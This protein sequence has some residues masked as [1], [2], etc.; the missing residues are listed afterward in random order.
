MKRISSL[1]HH[2]VYNDSSNS[3]YNSN[4]NN[5]KDDDND[6]EEWQFIVRH[7]T[8]ILQKSGQKSV[9]LMG[10]RFSEKHGLHK[11]T[12]VST[13]RRNITTHSAHHDESQSTRPVA[14][15]VIW[16]AGSV[17]ERTQSSARVSTGQ[18][19]DSRLIQTTEQVSKREDNGNVRRAGYVSKGGADDNGI[20]WGAE[21][22]SS[23]GKT[24][25]DVLRRREA[26]TDG[27]GE[28]PSKGRINE[29]RKLLVKK[30]NTE[31]EEDPKVSNYSDFCI[32][33][34]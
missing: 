24:S 22:T 29:P 23:K 4:Y 19:E 16:R 21:H 30:V 15:H 32:N 31:K 25:E 20:A 17:H 7:N 18:S 13:D 6:D 8:R 27:Y 2:T 26:L 5:D 12:S 11:S 33:D 34:E 10:K 28:F 1:N 3:N 14:E 9:K